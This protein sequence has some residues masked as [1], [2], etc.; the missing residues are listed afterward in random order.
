MNYKII[1]WSKNRK[2]HKV[3]ISR[4]QIKK[5]YSEIEKDDN[6]DGYSLPIEK[7]EVNALIG[8][9]Y[10]VG[11]SKCLDNGGQHDTD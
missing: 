11:K 10:G 3:K 8:G 2:G 4:E 6:I 7:E 9:A 5:L 1:D